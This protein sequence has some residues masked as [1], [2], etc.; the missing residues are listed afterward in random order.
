MIT[1]LTIDLG[2]AC[3]ACPGGD[4]GGSPGDSGS[5]TGLRLGVAWE[6]L[7]G[8]RHRYRYWVHLDGQE[9]ARGDDLRGGASHAANHPHLMVTLIG[10]LLADAES[11]ATHQMGRRGQDP[12]DGYLFGADAAERAYLLADELAAAQDELNAAH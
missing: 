2:S 4:L 5:P 1:A 9:L 12:P 8:D 10:F 3:D 7:D 11:Y 6:R